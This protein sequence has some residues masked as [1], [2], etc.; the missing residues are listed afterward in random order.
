MF[1]IAFL[2]L[3]AAVLA[4][5]P[6]YAGDSAEY[7]NRGIEYYMQGDYDSA[8]EHFT[9][10]IDLGYSHAVVFNNLGTAYYGKGDYNKAVENFLKAVDR[11]PLYISAYSN[12]GLSYFHLGDYMKATD[13]FTMA[14]NRD[15]GF[16]PAYKHRAF[17]HGRQGAYIL[18]LR[19]LQYYVY[20]SPDAEDIVQAS[21][22]IERLKSTIRDTGGELTDITGAASLSAGREEDVSVGES[23]RGGALPE[24]GGEAPE[25]PEETISLP[26]IPD[27]LLRKIEPILRSANDAWEE[28]TEIPVEDSFERELIDPVPDESQPVFEADREDHSQDAP[29]EESGKFYSPARTIQEITLP[30][31]PP[32]FYK[33]RGIVH[34]NR[35]EYQQALENFNEAIALDPGYG[36]AYKHRALVYRESGEYARA[37]NDLEYYLSITPEAP[38]A[39]KIKEIIEDLISKTR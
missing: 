3:S 26:D 28:E 12:A 34:Y 35:G 6:L 9:R 22:E 29:G 14:L 4:C 39:L 15:P 2:L 10:A 33:Y 25:K 27:T 5:I 18:A 13:Y 19:D 24:D 23:E 1:R 17:A 32:S 11:D 36:N 38:D 20:L 8:V 16:A 21:R 7:N 30:P 37:L 31:I